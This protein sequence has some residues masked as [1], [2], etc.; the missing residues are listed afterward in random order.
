[1]ELEC[2]WC[3]RLWSNKENQSNM[4]FCSIWNEFLQ[5][6]SFVL[7]EEQT[8]V[9]TSSVRTFFIIQL[10]TIQVFSISCYFVCIACRPLHLYFAVIMLFSSFFFLECSTFSLSN[11]IITMCYHLLHVYYTNCSSNL[12]LIVDGRPFPPPS[13]ETL[14]LKTSNI[15]FVW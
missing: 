5:T 4:S 2:W 7:V 15:I 1:M 13:T 3:W 9:K 12:A 10:L 14:P 6:S 8:S 11:F